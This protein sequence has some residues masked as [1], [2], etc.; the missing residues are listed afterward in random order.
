[1]PKSIA[2]VGRQYEIDLI[3]EQVQKWG[4]NVVVVIDGEGGI[5]KTRLL[6]RSFSDIPQN[7]IFWLYP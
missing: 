3:A 5:G 2:F 7:H 4:G 6:Q 1:M